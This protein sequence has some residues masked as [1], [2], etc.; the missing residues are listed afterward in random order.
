M[1][2]HNIPHHFIDRRWIYLLIAALLLT[3]IG[4]TAGKAYARQKPVTV[5]YVYGQQPGQFLACF[6]RDGKLTQ[7]GGD[8]AKLTDFDTCEEV[9][10][11]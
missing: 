6:K 4:A 9:L 10:Y 8:G 2:P 1:S 5:V 3:L 11:K 7:Q